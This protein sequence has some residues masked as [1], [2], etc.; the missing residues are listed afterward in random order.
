MPGIEQVLSNF[1]FPFSLIF[2]DR[3]FCVKDEKELKEKSDA[4]PKLN[5]FSQS[6]IC[7]FL[8][9]DNRLGPNSVPFFLI[10]L[11][12]T[13]FHLPFYFSARELYEL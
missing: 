4:G 11:K 13:S 1:S 9:N 12:P 8:P 3:M 10:P 7:T 6:Q 5:I 2:I